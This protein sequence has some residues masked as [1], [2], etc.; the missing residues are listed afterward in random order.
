[1]AEYL[2]LIYEDESSWATAGDETFQQ[3]MKGH[4][5]FGHANADSLRGGNALQPKAT[6]KTVRA[7]PS[8]RLIVTDGPFI[9][10]KESVAGYYLLEAA[11]HEEAVEKAKQIPAPFGGVEVRPVRVFE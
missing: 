8:G 7:D 1:M 9:E 4:E 3:V 6:A 10:T 2:A 11:S 5:E